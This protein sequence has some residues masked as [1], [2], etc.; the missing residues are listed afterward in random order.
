MSEQPTSPSDSSPHGSLDGSG[1][2]DHDQPYGGFHAYQFSTRELARLL[3]LRGEVLEARLG[4]G[5]YVR[6]LTPRRP[7]RPRRASRH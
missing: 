1:A 6:D 4:R 2:G 5:R 3:Q 7:R